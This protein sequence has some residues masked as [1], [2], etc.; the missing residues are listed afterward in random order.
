M[1]ELRTDQ[2]VAFRWYSE[3][4]LLPATLTAKV[5]NRSGAL[6]SAATVTLP[7]G[8][9]TVSSDSGTYIS[10]DERIDQLRHG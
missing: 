4:G 2:A 6:G 10:M 8:S 9:T 3:T 1:I 7:T 5:Y